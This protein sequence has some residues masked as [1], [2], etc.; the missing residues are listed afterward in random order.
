MW[1]Q[2]ILVPLSI[3]RR[4]PSCAR[5]SNNRFVFNLTD[6]PPYRV[7]VTGKLKPGQNQLELTV[8]NTWVNRPFLTIAGQ[9]APGNGIALKG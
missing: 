8:V 4:P 9:T 3:D 7:A 6:S 2:L 1:T 5:K